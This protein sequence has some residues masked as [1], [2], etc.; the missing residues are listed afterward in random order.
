[1][2]IYIRDQAKFDAAGAKHSQTLRDDVPNFSSVMPSATVTEI[3]G[4]ANS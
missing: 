1:V 4:A 2:N 3:Y